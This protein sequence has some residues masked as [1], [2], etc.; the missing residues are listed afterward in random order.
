MEQNDS[1]I[2]VKK[3][4]LINSLVILGLFICSSFCFFI[5]QIWIPLG[6]II[7]LIFSSI[8]LIILYNYSY[9]LTRP[10]ANYKKLNFFSFSIRLLLYGLGLAICIIPQAFGYNIFFWGT[11]FASYMI[12]TIIMVFIF[13]K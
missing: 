6:F 8:N 4:L 1:L 5:G 2:K 7:G 13:R 12:M 11:C 9:Y 10:G 3:T